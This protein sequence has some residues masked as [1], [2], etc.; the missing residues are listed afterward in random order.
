MPTYMCHFQESTFIGGIP[1]S[2]E[3]NVF[4]N[5]VKISAANFTETV[6]VLVGSYLCF[7]LNYSA[8]QESVLECL[9]GL[10]GLRRPFKSPNIKNL[11]KSFM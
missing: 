6:S 9:E 1:T 5:G 11:V 7:N 3:L 8:E 2:P 4:L 10:V